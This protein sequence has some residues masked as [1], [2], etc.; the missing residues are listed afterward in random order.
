[1]L[2]VYCPVRFSIFLCRNDHDAAPISGGTNLYCSDDT[3]FSIIPKSFSYFFLLVVWYVIRI[4]LC[5]ALGV[6]P[7]LRWMWAVGPDIAGNF[8]L[9]LNTVVASWSNSLFLYVLTGWQIWKGLR[10]IGLL[11]ICRRVYFVMLGI[12]MYGIACYWWW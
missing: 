12:W 3:S 7:S 6:E 9:L 10:I 8:A 4:E 2:V 11:L 5:L 1:M